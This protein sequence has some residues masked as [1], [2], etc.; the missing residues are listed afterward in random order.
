MGKLSTAAA[1]LA[2]FINHPGAACAVATDSQGKLG[3][4]CS[5]KGQKILN[6]SFSCVQNRLLLLWTGLAEQGISQP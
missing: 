5:E 6:F 2:G 3:Q 4:W 1:L